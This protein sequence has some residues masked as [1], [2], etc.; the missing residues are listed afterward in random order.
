MRKIMTVNSYLTNL[1]NRAIIRNQEKV[2]I[3]RSI[4]VLQTRLNKHFPLQLSEQLIFGS[5]S[6]GTILP[7]RMDKN[8]DI[9]Y[10][11]I[12]NDSDAKP[13]AYLDRLRRFIIRYYSSSS[14]AQSNPT[15]V[16]SLNHIKFELVPAINTYW[17]GLQI[18][19]KAR[20]YADWID[21]DPTGFNNKLTTANQ[22]NSNLIKPLIRLVKYWNARNG[23]VFESYELEQMVVNHEFFFVRL[24]SGQ[25]KDYFFDFMESLELGWGA[26]NWRTEKINRLH[27]LIKLTKD[28]LS[29][30]QEAKATDYIRRIFPP[31]ALPV[32]L[33]L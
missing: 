21:T 25:L 32:T 33:K 10:M 24:S 6:R 31:T 12:F 27:R 17:D 28:S 23:Y 29:R 22:N 7:R 9:D 4:T 2:S 3:Q 18:P 19:A 8:S 1:A 20:A 14:I 16:L 13:Q 26:A 5:Y 15:I 30:G 11:I